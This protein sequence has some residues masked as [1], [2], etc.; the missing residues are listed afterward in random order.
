[1]ANNTQ[2]PTSHRLLRLKQV[3]EITGLGKTKIYSLIK[4]NQFP[5]PKKIGRISAWL[6][7][8]IDD[9]VTGCSSK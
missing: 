4:L 8:D 3:L 1:M 6:N 2:N 7:T 5:A 9:W